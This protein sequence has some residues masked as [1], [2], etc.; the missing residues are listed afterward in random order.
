[1]TWQTIDTAP[2]DRAVIVLYKDVGHSETTTL[3][4][5]M[6]RDTTA[7]YYNYGFPWSMG[8]IPAYWTDLPPLPQELIKC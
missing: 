8:L 4:I 2:K 1:M 6:W 7:K 3:E 5:S